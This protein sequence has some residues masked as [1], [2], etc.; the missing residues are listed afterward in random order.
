[1]IFGGLAPIFFLAAAGGA[2]AQ[3]TSCAAPCPLSRADAEAILARQQ[4]RSATLAAAVPPKLLAKVKNTQQ[5]R[6]VKGNFTISSPR[7]RSSRGP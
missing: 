6:R 2:I 4:A 1:M 7:P 3:E 5:R